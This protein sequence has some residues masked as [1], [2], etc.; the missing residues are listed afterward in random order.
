ML[1]VIANVVAPDQI[2]QLRERILALKYVDGTLTAGWHAKLVKNNLQADRAQPEFA[3]LNKTVSD[4]I[5]G[6]PTVRIAARPKALTPLLFSRYSD[7]MT[8]GTHVDD[9]VIMGLR[10]DISLTLS[11]TDPRTYEG[12]ELVMETPGGEQA[13]KLPAGHLI[14]YPSTTLHRVNP[15]TS[16]ERLAA[17]GWM[18][19]AV[20]DAHARE[21]LYDLEIARRSMFEKTGK[22]RDFDLISKAT[23][24]LQR[25]WAEV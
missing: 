8:Y 6:N 3:A 5:L 13:F 12:G 18:Q 14:L 25:L 23:A 21:I 7:G 20:R 2:T 10:S 15:V 17:V 4:A 19:S 11:L 22:S 24:N 16:G 1:M 9:A